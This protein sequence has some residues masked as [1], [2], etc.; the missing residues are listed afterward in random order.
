MAVILLFFWFI[1]LFF[2]YKSIIFYLNF[3]IVHNIFIM[4][5]NLVLF[6]FSDTLSFKTQK[7]YKCVGCQH[8]PGMVLLTFESKVCSSNLY[9]PLMFHYFNLDWQVSWKTKMGFSMHET[10]F[11]LKN[12]LLLLENIEQWVLAIALATN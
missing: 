2:L 7:V 6:L 4:F 5:V 11:F 8:I 3:T 12:K 1:Q 10:R 9:F